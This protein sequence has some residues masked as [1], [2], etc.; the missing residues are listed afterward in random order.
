MRVF[1]LEF[2]IKFLVYMGKGTL[3]GTLPAKHENSA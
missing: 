2:Q 3:L 1:F